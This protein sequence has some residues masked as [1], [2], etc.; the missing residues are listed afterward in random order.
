MPG[1]IVIVAGFQ[2]IEDSPPEPAATPA[3]D[4][5]WAVA[6]CSRMPKAPAC[7]IA[8]VMRRAAN[9]VTA[10][11]SVRSKSLMEILPLSRML[12]VARSNRDCSRSLAYV[13]RSRQYGHAW[14]R[15]PAAS[16][17][18][19]LDSSE[20]ESST[21]RHGGVYVPLQRG[22]SQAA[23]IR[24]AQFFCSS[25]RGDARSDFQAVR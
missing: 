5:P 13:D 10:R 8:V 25:E 17:R 20:N 7:A 24:T 22:R 3:K 11:A 16:C 15:A 14:L 21:V 9:E 19:A 18:R 4:S 2:N 12:V 6:L 1:V 23:F